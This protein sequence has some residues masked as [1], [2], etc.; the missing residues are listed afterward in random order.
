MNFLPRRFKW[1][2]FGLGMIFFSEEL[3]SL[4][5]TCDI[6]VSKATHTHR[7]TEAWF[8]AGCCCFWA[9]SGGTCHFL[10]TVLLIGPLCISD[11]A[12][13]AATKASLQSCGGN[14]AKCVW[15][16]VC[17]CTRANYAFRVPSLFPRTHTPLLFLFPHLHESL[18]PSLLSIFL[19]HYIHFSFSGSFSPLSP[20]SCSIFLFLPKAAWRKKA[21]PG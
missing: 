7:L 9:S 2:Y 13:V 1:G 17:V 10:H 6:S 3:M 4:W 20:L 19:I 14:G 15:V 21:F 16:Y 8:I 11:E 5:F 12:N 18:L